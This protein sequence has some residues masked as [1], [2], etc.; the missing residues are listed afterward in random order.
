MSGTTPT[1]VSH[2]GVPWVAATAS[3]C[4]IGSARGKW[5]IAKRSFTMTAVSSATLPALK[6][7]PR[8]GLTPSAAK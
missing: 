4:P 2:C 8:D 7:R 5:S 1:T 6:S 3:R